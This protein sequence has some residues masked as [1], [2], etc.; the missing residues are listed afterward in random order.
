MKLGV[1]ILHGIGNH[2]PSFADPFVAKMRA[3]LGRESAADIIF[4]PCFWG[5]QLD[6]RERALHARMAP[7]TDKNRI[8]RELVIGGFGDLIA[9]N[10]PPTGTSHYYHA[11]HSEVYTALCQMEAKI[12]REG[13]RPETTPLLVMA[14]SLGCYIASNYIWDHQQ[15]NQWS[16][17]RGSAFAR[18]ETLCGLITFG[19]N[20]P[21]TGM[22]Y[23]TDLGQPILPY[24]PL[25]KDCFS[26]GGRRRWADSDKWLNLY[27]P[28]D[29][30]GMPLESVNSGYASQVRDVAINTGGLLFAH[31]S[32]WED[33]DF[34][35]H[36]GD[37]IHS[38]LNHIG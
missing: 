10:G 35:E 19:C 4:R 38:L 23:P 32:Y 27:D 28:D 3:Y 31:T 24:G 26:E 6:K 22:A 2:S 17:A 14:H 21:L 11:V 12:L 8:R 30:L 18:A 9:Y 20:L 16:F 25:A 15:K 33:A 36:A 13:G 1:L 5:G 37:R 29:I 34:I 7:D